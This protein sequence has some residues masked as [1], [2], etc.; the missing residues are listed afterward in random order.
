M[1]G[2]YVIN[3]ARSVERYGAFARLAA[4]AGL[5][6]ERV[7]AVDGRLATQDGWDGLDVDRFRRFNGRE[8]LPGEYGCYFSHIKA[9]QAFLDSGYTSAVIMEDDAEPDAALGPF[10]A[11][12]DARFSGQA[13]LVR[14][15]SH[16]LQLFEAFERPLA[17]GP[18]VGQCWLG[19][20]G[21][22]SAY[23]LSRSA[24]ATLVGR[25]VPVYCPFD[26][27]QERSWETGVRFCQVK[28]NLMP[29]PRPPD[30]T[31]AVSGPTYAVKYPPYRRLPAYWART[32]QLFRR[33][34]TCART[35]G[36]AGPKGRSHSV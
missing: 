28:P 8:P 3:L 14:L 18:L 34:A 9:M 16:R 21:S 30:S 7:E 22:G 10:T 4:A 2:Y 24:A 23:W 5:K 1:V 27:M 36:I 33:L 15:T 11:A 31:I 17:D 35:R 29:V 25:M 32:A 19:P 20:T 6:V 26:V 13:L 12:L